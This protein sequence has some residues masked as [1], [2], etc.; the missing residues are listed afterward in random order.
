[1]PKQTRQDFICMG[2][3]SVAARLIVPNYI[4]KLKDFFA[5]SGDYLYAYRFNKGLLRWNFIHDKIDYLPVPYA[6]VPDEPT[7]LVDFYATIYPILS[8]PDKVVVVHDFGYITS[9]QNRNL[10]P[11]P[12]SIFFSTFDFSSREVYGFF[13]TSPIP[14][15][16]SPHLESRITVVPR[17]ITEQEFLHRFPEY[18]Y[19]VEWRY[20]NFEPMY[21]YRFG[22]IFVIT[23]FVCFPNPNKNRCEQVSFEYDPV[24]NRI[25]NLNVS[26][27]SV[28]DPYWMHNDIMTFHNLDEIQIGDDRFLLNIPDHLL[29]N[30]AYW[31]VSFMEFLATQDAALITL[32]SSSTYFPTLDCEPSVKYFVPLEV[33]RSYRSDT[34]NHCKAIYVYPEKLL[35]LCP[36][37]LDCYYPDIMLNV[38][39]HYDTGDLAEL[40][41]RVGVYD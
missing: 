28:F 23:N 38:D 6:L 27:F 26:P 18:K 21:G 35:D 9:F 34:L 13:F 2:D 22:K 39:V 41:R 1:M 17:G 20:S 36:T 7:K 29:P 40:F 5:R 24:E 10:N 11:R 25:V 19:P 31:Y 12:I 4:G 30:E 16:I 37:L 33:L 8:S 32:S 3:M 14:P 15:V